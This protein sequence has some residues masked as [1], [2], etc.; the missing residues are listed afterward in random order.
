MAQKVVPSPLIRVVTQCSFCGGAM[1]DIEGDKR[2]GSSDKLNLN[3]F[4]SHNVMYACC[5][6]FHFRI[7]ISHKHNGVRNK[8]K[9]LYVKLR[10]RAVCGEVCDLI[11]YP[12]GQD[13]VILT[14][15]D[16]PF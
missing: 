14:A 1:R 10:K 16:C 11:G 3:T 9:L 6:M 2:H 7:C 13:G 12:S 5:T 15:R 4:K 8:V